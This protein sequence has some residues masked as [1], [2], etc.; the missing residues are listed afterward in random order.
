[1]VPNLDLS[2]MSVINYAVCHLEVEDIV[3]CGHYF[4]GGVNAAMQ[5]QDLGLLNPWLRNI[6]DVYRLH[7]NEL[8]TIKDEDAKY[9]RLVELNVQEQCVNVLKAAEVQMAYR[10]DRISIHG[11]IFDIRNGQ[12]IDLKINFEN[13]LEGLREIYRLS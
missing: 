12:L 5:A 1:M 3:I 10:A 11:W 8:E 7:K 9:N 13:V 4:C 2:V 6:R